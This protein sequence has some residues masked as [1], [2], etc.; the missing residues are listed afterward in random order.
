M[1]KDE[2]YEKIKDIMTKERFEYEISERKR[3]YNNLLDDDAIALLIVDELGRTPVN[4]LKIS[5]LIDGVNA[6]LIVDIESF[7][8][9]KI[10]KNDRELRMRKLKVRDDTGEC[11]LVLWNEE[12][13]NYSFLK[14]GDR[15]KIINCFTKLN[16]YGLQ[17]SLGKWGHIVK[18]P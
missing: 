6:S 11:T 15:I 3:K 9:S 12:I 16:H 13:D 1:D 17:I 8:D 4:W 5:D 7:E 14:P 10:R 2:L 18:V